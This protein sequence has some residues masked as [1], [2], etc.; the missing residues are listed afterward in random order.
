MGFAYVSFGSMFLGFLAWYRGLALGGTA[1]VGQT[2]LLQ[3]FFT[4]AGGW[5]IAGERFEP[6]ALLFLA[7]VVAVVALGRRAAVQR[8]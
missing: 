3:G 4:L 7:A 5:A 6:D 1:R 8:R 2:Q